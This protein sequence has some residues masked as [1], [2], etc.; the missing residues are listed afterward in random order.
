MV[1]GQGDASG[2]VGHVHNVVGNI[3]LAVDVHHRD[4]Y[5]RGHR[6]SDRVVVAHDQ[7]P[8]HLAGG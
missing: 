1:Y 4:V 3:R 2:V 6:G 8:V 5:L 7:Y